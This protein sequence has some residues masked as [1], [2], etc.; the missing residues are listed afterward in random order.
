LGQYIRLS[1]S[2]NLLDLVRTGVFHFPFFLRAI[3]AA[4]VFD[5]PDIEAVRERHE[6]HLD[7][8]SKEDQLGEKLHDIEAMMSRPVGTTKYALLIELSKPARR[9]FL[10]FVA[11]ALALVCAWFLLFT[12]IQ[13]SEVFSGSLLADVGKAFLTGGFVLAS[14]V[15]LFLAFSF[16]KRSL[17]R[18]RDPSVSDCYL[19]AEAIAE[20]LDVPCV[21]MGHT[22]VAD[23]RLF[24]RRHGSYINTGTW[25]P[26]PGPWDTI[27]PNARQFTFA[28]IEG[29]QMDLLRWDDATRGWDAVTL[30]EEY[31][32]STLERLLT[33][34]DSGDRAAGAEDV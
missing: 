34:S 7:R 17:Y 25:I 30:L 1:Y 27:K 33:D 3:K 32:P 24:Q 16:L 13:E 10:F 23:H 26:H 15:A 29:S 11:F 5:T 6:G 2:H 18:R 31:R 8:L 22:H 20:L 4:P 19:R 21:S 9:A 14:V 12:T 28:R